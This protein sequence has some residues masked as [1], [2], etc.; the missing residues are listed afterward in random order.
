MFLQLSRSKGSCTVLCLASAQRPPENLCWENADYGNG[1]LWG[2]IRLNFRPH[3]PELLNLRNRDQNR[4]SCLQE[5]RCPSCHCK[6][7][8]IPV[9]FADDL[10]SQQSGCSSV[11]SA[12]QLD[13]TVTDRAAHTAGSHALL[14]PSDFAPCE[15]ENSAPN[16]PT[17]LRLWERS[18][19]GPDLLFN[20]RNLTESFC[21]E[22]PVLGQITC[23][24]WE[25]YMCV[26]KFLR[27]VAFMWN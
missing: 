22:N 6:E 26:N 5:K 9:C 3:A 23:Q 2:S 17:L 13:E 8:N 11:A 18:M 7:K 14:L 15:A 27:N 16:W 1:A 12:G 19:N 20:R 10:S 4:S 25:N 21:D 24:R